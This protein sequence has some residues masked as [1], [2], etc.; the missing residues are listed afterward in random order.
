MR[1]LFDIKNRVMVVT[2]GSGV[3]GAAMVEYLAEQ[4]AK[5]AVLARN[6]DKGEA[7]VKSVTDK[8]YEA[9][10]FQT[11]PDGILRYNPSSI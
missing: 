8:G 1:N 11:D 5:V 4:G 2:G 3:L 10:F 7:L 6:R 9:A